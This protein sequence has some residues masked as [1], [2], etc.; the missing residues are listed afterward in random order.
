MIK[1]GK[2]NQSLRRSCMRA[3]RATHTTHRASRGGQCNSA[4]S[5]AR[6]NDS[7]QHQVAEVML[8]LLL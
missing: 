2:R 6:Y 1:V 8:I 4:S 7:V 3:D 5:G